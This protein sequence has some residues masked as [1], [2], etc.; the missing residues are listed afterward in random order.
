MVVYILFDIP[1]TKTWKMNPPSL[2]MS[3]HIQLLPH[4][5]TLC[6]SVGAYV[7]VPVHVT[8]KTSNLQPAA[9]VRHVSE[10]S[11]DASLQTSPG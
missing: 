2:N 10:F 9:T 1:P 6:L 8:M 5:F 7:G 3:E 4:M 11:G